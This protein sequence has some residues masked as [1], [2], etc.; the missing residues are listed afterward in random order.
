MTKQ[1]AWIQLV[2][3]TL[4]CVLASSVIIGA[5]A[6][7][8]WMDT[9]SLPDLSLRAAMALFILGAISLMVFLAYIEMRYPKEGGGALDKDTHLVPGGDAGAYYASGFSGSPIADHDDVDGNGDGDGNDAGDGGG[10][11]DGG[12]SD[13][14]GGGDGGGDG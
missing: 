6:M 5:F 12:G 11:G 7:W 8:H 3:W 14:G 2:K 1:P 13:G 4:V 9:G 10:W